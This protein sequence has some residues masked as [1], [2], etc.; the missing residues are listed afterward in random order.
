MANSRA[1]LAAP[2]ADHVQWGGLG[3]TIERAAENLAIDRHNALA[4]PRKLRHEALEDG[5]ELLGVQH[6]EQTAE[7]VVAGQ[8]NSRVRTW[9]RKVSF[10]RTNSAMATAFCPPHKTVQSAMNSSSWKSCRPAV[11]VSGMTGLDLS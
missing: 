4:L 11:S 10:A 8:P 7:R 9:R 5:A 3:G 2:G 6:P 1:L